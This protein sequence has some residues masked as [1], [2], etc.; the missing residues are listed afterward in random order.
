MSLRALCTI[1]ACLALLATRLLGMHAHVSPTHETHHPESA[2]EGSAAAYVEGTEA[3]AHSHAA[4]GTADVDAQATPMGDTSPL[5]FIAI[6]FAFSIVFTLLLRQ[7]IASVFD[8]HDRPPKSR[9]RFFVLPPSQAPPSTQL[10][11]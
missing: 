11:C 3:H 10:H 8:P 5:K 6:L 4:H 1:L 9:A 2:V 7:H